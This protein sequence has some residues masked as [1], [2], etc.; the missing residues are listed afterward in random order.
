MTGPVDGVRV[1]GSTVIPRSELRWRFSRSGGPG[2]QGVNTADSR[3]E[4]RWDVAATSALPEPLRV[5]ALERLAHRLIDGVL[6]I[7]VSEERAQLQNRQI[8]ERRLAAI[9]A[10]AIAPPPARRHPTRPTKGSVE[11][12]IASKRRTS[13]IKRNR[14]RPDD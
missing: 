9:V 4:L 6:S 1:R 11:R 10:E 14:Q 13:E 12:R 5:R 3:V 7:V 2:G 8:A